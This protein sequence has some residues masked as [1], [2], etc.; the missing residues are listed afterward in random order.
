MFRG[1][2]EH[3]IDEKGRLSIPAKFRENIVESGDST[4]IVTIFDQCLAAYTLEEWK[5]LEAKL[6]NLEQL[7]PKVRAFQ[8]YFISGAQEC[9]LDKAGRIL[10]SASQREF[11][12]LKKDCFIVGQLSKFE[13]WSDERWNTVF[14]EISSQFES[15]AS[16]VSD[17]GMNL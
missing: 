8:R 10:I 4:I 2:F 15:L 5:I 12:G 11:A 17:L 16:A 3:S 14:K 13:I 7:N 9:Q 6:A 1:L